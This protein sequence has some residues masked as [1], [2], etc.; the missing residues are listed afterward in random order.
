MWKDGKHGVTFAE[1]MSVFLDPRGIAA[2]D[3]IHHERFVLIGR[4]SE[5]RVLFV[6][7]AE[8][9]EDRVRMISAR[10]ASRAQRKV[11]EHGPK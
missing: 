10:K 7:S 11:Y 4:S 8:T 9:A 1:A 6:V 2:P 3:K 5:L